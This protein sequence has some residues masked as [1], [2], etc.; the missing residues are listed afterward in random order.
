MNQLCEL[1]QRIET[2]SASGTPISVDSDA[3]AMAEIL[4]RQRLEWFRDRCPLEFQ[5]PLCLEKMPAPRSVAMK[6]LSWDVAF[7]GLWLWSTRSGQGKTRTMW[8]LVKVARIEKGRQIYAYTGQQWADEFWRHHMDG[9]ADELWGWLKRWDVLVLDDVDKINVSDVRQ[10][11]ALREL[12]DLIYR[13]RM[14][15]LVTSNRPIAWLTEVLGASAERR[16]RDSF[17]EISFDGGQG[18]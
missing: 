15:C 13:E 11:R 6:A 16:V 2:G 10:Q 12:F 5:A 17:A 3:R 8:A 4:A 7:P 9:T 1:I 14:P 18:Q